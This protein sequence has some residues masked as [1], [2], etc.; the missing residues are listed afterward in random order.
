M[1]VEKLNTSLSKNTLNLLIYDTDPII[2]YRIDFEDVDVIQN[3]CISEN[4]NKFVLNKI[5][6]IPSMISLN[7]IPNMFVLSTS[8]YGMF[9]WNDSNNKQI[10]MINFEKHHENYITIDAIDM[11]KT[12]NSITRNIMLYNEMIS[13]ENAKYFHNT[14]S[15]DSLLDIIT[16]REIFAIVRKSFD[17]DENEFSKFY[18]NF[19]NTTNIIPDMSIFNINDDDHLIDKSKS[20]EIDHNRDFEYHITYGK[21]TDVIIQNN[22]LY[23]DTTQFTPKLNLLYLFKTKNYLAFPIVYNFISTDSVYEITHKFYNIEKQMG[24]QT[25]SYVVYVPLSMLLFN[26]KSIV[27]E[28]ERK[29]LSNY[30][31]DLYTIIILK[32]KQIFGKNESDE[33]LNTKD[34]LSFV[35]YVYNVIG[36]CYGVR[37]MKYINRFIDLLNVHVQQGDQSKI[38]NNIEHYLFTTFT[39]SNNTNIKNINYY[40]AYILKII[41]NSIKQHNPTF[42]KNTTDVDTFNINVKTLEDLHSIYNYLTDYANDSYELRPT[43]FEDL[44]KLEINLDELDEEMLKDVPDI[45]IC[46]LSKHNQSINYFNKMK[47]YN[48]IY[49]KLI[50]NDEFRSRERDQIMSYNLT[51]NACIMFRKKRNGEYRRSYA[52][53]IDDNNMNEFTKTLNDNMF[54]L[55]SIYKETTKKTSDRK[56]SRKSFTRI[57]GYV[58]ENIEDEDED[59]EKLSNG[60]SIV[61]INEVTEIKPALGLLKYLFEHEILNALK[62]TENLCDG[63]TVM[64]EYITFDTTIDIPCGQLF[65]NDMNMTNIANSST[66]LI[67]KFN[68]F[69]FQRNIDENLIYSYNVGSIPKSITSIDRPLIINDDDVI[70]CHTMD[71]KFVNCKKYFGGGIENKNYYS[72]IDYIFS[73]I[74][75]DS[76]ENVT[77]NFNKDSIVVK[78]QFY[79]MR[80]KK[81]FKKIWFN[82]TFSSDDEFNKY[83]T[84]FL[85]ES[86]LLTDED[87]NNCEKYIKHYGKPKSHSHSRRVVN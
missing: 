1:N 86:R 7:I 11:L 87:Q 15:V 25:Y 50:L 14:I 51:I 24:E 68:G 3:R 79:L 71:D 59:D 80:N 60:D 31:N 5:L 22:M 26:I 23:I 53:L 58:D 83:V 65:V 78:S 13:K 19:N 75:I 4:E 61:S 69:V 48:H 12:Y 54:P 47:F 35:R 38:F 18:E 39:T 16:L 56:K 52:L 70:F 9:P 20:L 8:K 29:K 28:T 17:Y 42:N 49:L 41:F 32:Y 34:L 46:Y 66:E 27:I 6:D 33:K 67:N 81:I 43:I 85:N 2:D 84:Q 55:Y 73:N 63:P 30:L 44:D 72:V 76:D 40:V 77:F 64:Y 21:Q 57:E 45:D 10:Y 36:G 37:Y 62:T 82:S 74:H